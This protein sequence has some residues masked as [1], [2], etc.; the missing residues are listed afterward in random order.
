MTVDWVLIGG[1]C[2]GSYEA[3]STWPPPARIRAVYG[4]GLLGDG[5]PA[6]LDLPDD[7]PEPGEKVQEYELRSAGI[8]CTHRR[9]RGCVPVATYAPAGWAPMRVQRAMRVAASSLELAQPRGL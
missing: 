3:T 4:G 6:V 1:P 7:G 5:P 9:G 2:E 8:Y